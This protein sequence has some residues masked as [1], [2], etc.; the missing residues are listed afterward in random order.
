MFLDNSKKPVQYN[1]TRSGSMDRS[2]LHGMLPN[3]GEFALPPS[4][5]PQGAMV[6]WATNN[7]K[8]TQPII[9]DPHMPLLN[10]PNPTIQLEEAARRLHEEERSKF[11]KSKY[12]VFTRNL[13][14]KYPK[15]LIYS[16]HSKSSNSII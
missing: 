6:D 1:A 15:Y 13:N 9:Q 2:G 10:P 3:K 8:P 16:S 11:P 14:L 4:Q 12:V 5:V 7:V